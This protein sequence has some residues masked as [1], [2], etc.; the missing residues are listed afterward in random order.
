MKKQK[1]SS[2]KLKN[3][4]SVLSVSW[5]V[6]MI[7]HVIFT[8]KIPLWNF[9][10]NIPTFLMVIIPIAFLLAEIVLRRRKQKIALLIVPVISLALG[11]TQF[12]VNVYA[13]VKRDV[14]VV[15][16]KEIKVF[17]WNT[18][19]WDQH[20]DKDEFYAF[21]KR[22]D[23]DVY[24]LQEHLHGTINWDDPKS[25]KSNQDIDKSKLFRICTAVPGFPLHYLAIDDSERIK[26]EFPDYYFT[27]NKQFV[28]IS[29]YPITKSHL[30][31]SD[32]YAITDIDVE[33]MKLRLFNVH[34]LLHVEP[35]NP[36]VPYFYEALDRRFE[37]RELAFNNLMN[38][39]EKTDVPYVI[40]GDFNTTKALGVMSPL[41]REHI[42]A[43]QYSKDLIPLT[44]EYLGLKAW[45]FDYVLLPKAYKDMQVVC[46]ENID[47]EGLSDHDAQYF[48][49]GIENN[50][51]VQLADSE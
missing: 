16:R 9:F 19:C 23:A 33:G 17:N 47:Q 14:P 25:D 15:A 46:F 45:R 38:D 31:V 30:D 34:M 21:M 39:I 7:F 22:H 1:N 28:V 4:A 2:Q 48:V 5:M 12:D 42:D 20:K 40:S 13:F 6:F 37:A 35:G 43:V 18:E 3:F 10:G 27:I 41:L 8:G 50:R 36:F 24:I 29:R 49:I 44:F 51:S 32:Q 26:E 11:I